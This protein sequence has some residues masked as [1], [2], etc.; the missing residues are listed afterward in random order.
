MPLPDFY[1][2]YMK[3]RLEPG[4]FVEA[5]IPPAAPGAPGSRLLQDRKRFDRTSRPSA[6][7][8][9]IELDGETGCSD[10]LAF[11]GMAATSSAPRQAEAALLG[12]PW[13]E[14]Q[15]AGARAAGADFTP[16]TDMRASAEHRL[17][18]ARLVQRFWL[19]NPRRADGA[20]SAGADQRLRHLAAR[21]PTMNANSLRHRPRR[22]SPPDR[23]AS[24]SAAHESAH[25]HVAGEAAYIDDLPELAG[26]LHCAL[27]LGAG[28]AWHGAAWLGIDLDTLRA[29]PGVVAVLTAADIPGVN[30]CG[31]IVSDDPS[32][33][34]AGRWFDGPANCATSASR[35]RRDRPHAR[36]ARR[37]AAKA[38]A[39]ARRSRP[40]PPCSPLDG[41]C[42]GP[43]RLPPMHLQRGDAGGRRRRSP[44]RRIA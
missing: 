13:N 8:F 10:R 32:I 9:A 30:D 34:P 14:G 18:V 43:V 12:Q 38:K 37:A 29:L 26:T 1:L 11:G 25:L 7:A 15:R 44:P 5:V 17:Q 41:A 42:A 24:A 3:N 22:C 23:P 39:G 4:E 16:L 27:G 2:D 19:E 35:V 21:G 28:G 40:L 36:A 31:S 20:Q 6:P 33:V